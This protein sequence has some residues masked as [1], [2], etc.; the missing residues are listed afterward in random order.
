MVKDK[1]GQ[2]VPGSQDGKQNQV[3][4]DNPVNERASSEKPFKGSEER[5][6]KHDFPNANPDQKKGS[7]DKSLPSDRSRQDNQSGSQGRNTIAGANKNERS[8]QDANQG[9][10]PKGN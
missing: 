6:Q 1:K 2:M 4:R 7:A 8:L 5:G 9:R 10:N 3:N